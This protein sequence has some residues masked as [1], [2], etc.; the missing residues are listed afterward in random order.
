MIHTEEIV[1]QAVKAIRQQREELQ[2][3]VHALIWG[4]WGVGKTFS[5]QRIAKK[6]NDVFYMKVPA[7]D[8][9]RSKLVK[10]IGLAVGA[11]YRMSLEATKDLIKFHLTTLRVKPVLLLDEAQRVLKKP[12]LLDELKDLAEDEDTQFSYALLGDISV[13]R[14]IAQ[15]PHSLHKRIIIKKE[16]QPLAEKTVE[17]IIKSVGLK[18][19]QTFYSVAKERGWTTLDVAIVAR[20]ISKLSKDEITAEDIKRVAVSLG[21]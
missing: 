10:M 17:E 5:A 12:T 14:I 7:D 8:L 3:P 19:G 13:P 6:F 18:D 15:M 1:L 11:G 2:T 21:R 20:V 16:L 9:T 4:T